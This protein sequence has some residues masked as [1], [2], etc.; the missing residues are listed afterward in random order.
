MDRIVSFSS[1]SWTSHIPLL[2]CVQDFL[3]LLHIPL[4]LYLFFITCQAFP[5]GYD[6][7]LGIHLVLVGYCTAHL[8]SCH[9]DL[10]DMVVFHHDWIQGFL[11][12]PFIHFSFHFSFLCQCFPPSPMHAGKF[13]CQTRLSLHLYCIERS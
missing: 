7:L 6:S 10:L 8:S 9:H 3:N 1:Y 5:R 11:L 12:L 13:S 4:I 2:C